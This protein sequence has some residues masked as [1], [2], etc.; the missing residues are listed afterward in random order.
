MR[1]KERN[2]EKFT[3]IWILGE[4]Q[5]QRQKSHLIDKQYKSGLFRQTGMAREI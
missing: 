3:E 4:M 5:I 1:R 2:R